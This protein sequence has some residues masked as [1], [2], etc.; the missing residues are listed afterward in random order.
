[1]MLKT[2]SPAARRCAR[3]HRDSSF[4]HSA[5]RQLWR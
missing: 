3:P 2:W 5:R 1:M 4:H